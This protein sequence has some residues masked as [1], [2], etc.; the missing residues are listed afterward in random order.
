MLRARLAMLPART[1]CA[2][3]GWPCSL[4]G[5]SGAKYFARWPL[6]KLPHLL[7]VRF[8]GGTITAFGNGNCTMNAFELRN[9]KTIRHKGCRYFQ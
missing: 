2:P 7:R 3:F 1:A 9:D 8:V 5:A 4:R 6:H